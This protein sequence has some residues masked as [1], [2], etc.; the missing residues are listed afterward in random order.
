MFLLQNKLLRFGPVTNTLLFIHIEWEQ[1]RERRG[2]EVETRRVP[3]CRVNV[4]RDTSDSE[5][6]SRTWWYRSRTRW[7]P[8]SNPLPPISHTSI[9][10]ELLGRVTWRENFNYAG[11]QLPLSAPVGRFWEALGEDGGGW[12]LATALRDQTCCLRQTS[13]TPPNRL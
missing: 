3:G 5:R 12:K 6:T 7:W 9:P 13:K 1:A 10:E 4:H 8:R 2:E 11:A